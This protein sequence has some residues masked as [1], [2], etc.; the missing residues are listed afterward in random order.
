MGFIV[1]KSFYL[2]VT[3]LKK[4]DILKI[5]GIFM[6]NFWINQQEKGFFFDY[7]TNNLRSVEIFGVKY[8]GFFSSWK[9]QKIF[10]KNDKKEKKTKLVPNPNNVI[11]SQ[12][13]A[14]FNTLNE[15]LQFF[16]SSIFLHMCPLHFKNLNDTETEQHA[17]F[18]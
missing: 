16:R 9:S 7:G 10:I 1:T 15:Q 8:L 17:S 12:R 11:N 14:K 2:N 5:I 18:F 4:S 3:I 6:R 13:T